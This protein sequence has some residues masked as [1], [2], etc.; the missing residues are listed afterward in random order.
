MS[1]ILNA[2][3]TLREIATILDLTVEFTES[4]KFL[5]NLID[6]IS[7]FEEIKKSSVSFTREH[8]ID[9]INE[10]STNQEVGLLIIPNNIHGDISYLKFPFIRSNNPL[11]SIVKLI[12]YFYSSKSFTAGINTQANIHPEATIDKSCHVGSF[13]VVGA[14]STI[15]AGT[16][17][18]PNVSI[19]PDVKIG[20]NCTIHSGAVIREGT[21]IE[22]NVIIHGGAVIGS[23]GF[24]YFLDESGL[25]SVP[26]V[27][28]V[29]I[30]S[31]VEIGANTCID[32]ATL[33]KTFIDK[34]TKIDNE[35][36]I[37]HNVKIGSN[38][39]ICG[40]AG[41]AGSTTIGDN[42]V[43][44]GSAGI[45]DHIQICNGTRIAAMAGVI[46]SIDKK[47]DYAGFPAVPA[48]RWRKQIRKLDL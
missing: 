42:V 9:K 46:S 31:N 21:I 14:N 6:S 12:P 30:S 27:G 47:G 10:Q 4:N 39:I 11:S 18:H 2:K 40:Q 38:T 25:T 37:G 48:H 7:P 43:I 45:K 24:G 15:D 3:L 33:G 19:Y 34:N 36:Q 26:Q 22:N 8:R 29:H 17:I 32:R 5:D 13:S 41:I 23:E 28:I 20:K 1:K 35:V 44:G 16:I